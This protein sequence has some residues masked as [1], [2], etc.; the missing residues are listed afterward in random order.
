MTKTAV[1]TR[2][3][4]AATPTAP[5]DLE[6]AHT[7]LQGYLDV[8]QPCAA[9]L[10]EVADVE[11]KALESVEQALAALGQGDDAVPDLRTA[12]DGLTSAQSRL[13]ASG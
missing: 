11:R 4:V 9:A 10:L 6:R 3:R 2:S 7:V 13:S 5:H 12:L 1:S 8:H